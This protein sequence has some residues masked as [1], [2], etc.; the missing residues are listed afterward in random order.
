ML[1]VKCGNCEREFAKR[2]YLTAHLKVPSNYLCLKHSLA[3]SEK[4]T[5]GKPDSVGR[6]SEAAIEA[7]SGG[8]VDFPMA[9]DGASDS[10][11]ET[12]VA[13]AMPDLPA[14]LPNAPLPTPNKDESPLDNFQQDWI[15]RSFADYAAESSKNRAW[16][17]AEYIAAIELM[18]ILTVSGAPLALCDAVMKWH[19]ANIKAD[20]AV[21]RDNLLNTL[22]S[23]YNVCNTKPHE[24]QT[25]LPHS[26][27]QVKIPCHDV[28]E[29]TM[30]LL[31]DPR[32]QEG[33]YLWHNGDPLAPPPDDW[34]ELRDINDGLAYRKTYD[35][36]IRP[37][38]FTESGR[39]RVLLPL[40]FYMDG[41]VTGF[42]ENLSLELVK[43]TFGIFNSKAREKDYTWRVLGAVPQ[44]QAVK[45]AAEEGIQ[46]SSHVEAAGYVTPTDSEDED[47]GNLRTFTGEFEFGDCINSSDDEDD[48][49][50]IPVPDTAAM[51]R[52][53]M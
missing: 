50:G 49:C 10:G 31:T 2:Q 1:R 38:P 26:C 3:S 34:L 45:T 40:L 36:L 33:D 25:F 39:K 32:I 9:D 7:N 52:M 18:H 23:R 15:R 8:A 37:Q 11:N 19:V 43:F 27:V 12:D 53:C 44:Y 24:V 51:C 35:E 47:A 30:D 41:C 4:C 29:M 6:T 48:M 42:N 21:T 16:M 17:N 20:Q 14:G 22:R 5:T 28:M 46:A 13:Q